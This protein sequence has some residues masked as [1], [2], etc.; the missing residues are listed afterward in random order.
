MI[1]MTRLA[2]SFLPGLLLAAAPALAQPAPA[3]DPTPP[4]APMRKLAFL[5]G[6]WQGEAWIQ[7]G[8]ERRDTVAQLESVEWRVGGEVLLIQGTGRQGERVVHSALATLAWDRTR[9]A[10]TMWAYAAGRGSLQPDVEVGEGSL[11][12]SFAVPGGGRRVRY[13]ARLDEQGRWVESGETSTDG[14][15]WHPFMGMTL[16]RR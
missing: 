7:M 10:Y 6:E 16:T 2:A 5:V 3:A 11:V 4:E 9:Q 8:P 1:A 15:T 13:T 14:A 12:W